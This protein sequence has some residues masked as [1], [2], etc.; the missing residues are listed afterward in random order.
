MTDQPNL[1]THMQTLDELLAAIESKANKICDSHMFAISQSKS[2]AYKE[3]RSVNFVTFEGT[4]KSGQR[5]GF[6]Q[7]CD[8][9]HH[10]AFMLDE[11][12]KT[13]K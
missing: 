12:L 6:I 2:K 13:V 1:F 4:A 8:G 10:G 9:F 11:F 5:L 3:G 7:S